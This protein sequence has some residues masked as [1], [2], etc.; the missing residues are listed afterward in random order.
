[1]LLLEIRP[2]RILCGMVFVPP[3]LLL[4]LALTRTISGYPYYWFA[5][6]VIVAVILAPWCHRPLLNRITGRFALASSSDGWHW[7]TI[8]RHDG[9]VQSWRLG[10]WFLSHGL[11]VLYLRRREG[12]GGC[13]LVLP[14]DALSATMHRRLRAHLWQAGAG[15]GKTGSVST[16]DV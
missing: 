11:V 3:V 16:R 7:T 4:M 14:R 15:P 10:N 6:G 12:R 8:R 5:V 13:A 9:R 1:M 2:S